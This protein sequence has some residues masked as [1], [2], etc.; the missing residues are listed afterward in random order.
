MAIARSE[1]EDFVR[2]RDIELVQWF[3]DLELKLTG[4]P[5]AQR[6]HVAP[7]PPVTLHGD[8]DRISQAVLNLV[9]NAR[10]HT[11]ADTTIW[12]SATV[13]DDAVAIAV[14]DDGPGIPE[15]IREEAFR[16]FVRAGETPSS[17]GLGLSV[18]AAVAA[19]HGGEVT[20]LTGEDGTRI[21]LRLPWAPDEGPL[22]D[23]LVDDAPLHAADDL[24][25][26]GSDHTR[27]PRAE[28]ADDPT[29]RIPRPNR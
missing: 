2:P 12:I 21:E 25:H 29:I 9:D 18:V 14:T 23:E 17:T 20:L 11:P 5:T 24:P 7:P 13:T 19:A 4:P 10:S 26:P 15:A 3:E 6:V 28:D 22:V 16:P 1:M 27:E 8:P